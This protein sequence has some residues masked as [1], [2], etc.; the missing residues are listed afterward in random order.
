MDGAQFHLLLIGEA[1][2][3]LEG[4]LVWRFFAGRV[5]FAECGGGVSS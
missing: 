4:S 5:V 1:G 3:G 2:G